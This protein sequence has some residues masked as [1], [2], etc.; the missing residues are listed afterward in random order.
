[1]IKKSATPIGIMIF[2]VPIKELIL[3]TLLIKKQFNIVKKTI[4]PR[5]NIR[6][7][8]DKTTRVPS[9]VIKL[10]TQKPRYCTEDCTSRGRYTTKLNHPKSK[11][12]KPK[13]LL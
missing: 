10:L 13:V 9:C 3:V 1:M 7:Y 2:Q 4:N 12:T 6:P 11:N 8:V 5:E